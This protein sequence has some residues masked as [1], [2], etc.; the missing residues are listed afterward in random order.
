V[1]CKHYEEVPKVEVRQEKY[2]LPPLG[3]EMS[4]KVEENGKN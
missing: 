2:S 4:E 1:P 3:K